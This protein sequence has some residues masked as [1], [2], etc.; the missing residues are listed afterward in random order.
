MA[1]QTEVPRSLVKKQSLSI[2]TNSSLNKLNNIQNIEKPIKERIKS[3]STGLI[4]FSLKSND[5]NSNN[6]V[7]PNSKDVIEKVE[8]EANN[9]RLGLPFYIPLD[10][11]D[12][13]TNGESET[14]SHVPLSVQETKKNEKLFFELA[15][16]QRQVMELKDKLS[17]AEKELKQL[18][19]KYHEHIM[20]TSPERVAKQNDIF[21]PES[22]GLRA[23]NSVLGL[24]KKSSILNFGQ[25]DIQMNYGTSEHG[26]AGEQ[27]WP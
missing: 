20:Q 4:K 13:S 27:V 3:E 26:E 18:E 21:R 15:S 7:K 23:R 12:E 9:S 19:M 8:D 5:N 25:R 11:Q 6:S 14:Q 2:L 24:A 10:K 17:L 22:A 16:K 1:Q